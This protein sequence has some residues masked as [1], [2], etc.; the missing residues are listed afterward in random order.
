MGILRIKTQDESLQTIESRK[1]F[2]RTSFRR[3]SVE[4]IPPSNH[5]Q[6]KN[7]HLQL[8]NDYDAMDDDENTSNLNPLKLSPSLKTKSSY[9]RVSPSVSVQFDKVIVRTYNRTLGDNPSCFSGAPVSLSWE[10]NPRHEEY[11]VHGYE[12]RRNGKRKTIENLRLS[13]HDRYD[14][15][16]NEFDVSMDEILTK[17]V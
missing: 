10:Y 2:A 16:V 1:N 9:K 14:M 11:S 6:G 8:I 17:M 4:F 5:E 12:M 13:N 3:G 15:L 7:H